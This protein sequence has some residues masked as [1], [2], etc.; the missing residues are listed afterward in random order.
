M[1]LSKR[2]RKD[3]RFISLAFC[4]NGC[5][6]HQPASGGGGASVVLGGGAVVSSASAVVVLAAAGTFG[7]ADNK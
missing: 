3:T 1:S 5:A 6:E 7:A 2:P 4:S